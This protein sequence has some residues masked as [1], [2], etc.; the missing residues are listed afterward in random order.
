[1]KNEAGNNNSLNGV[2]A[3]GYV[4]SQNRSGGQAQARSALQARFEYAYGYV[5]SFG[6]NSVNNN[7]ISNSTTNLSNSSSSPGQSPNKLST[8]GGRTNWA[9]K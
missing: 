1:M 3:N 2:V 4:R 6:R 8:T 9:A 5:P 7:S